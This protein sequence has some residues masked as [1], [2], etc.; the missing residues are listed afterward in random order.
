M[1]CISP[2]S[3]PG[4]GVP[5][6]KKGQRTTISNTRTRCVPYQRRRL[7]SPPSPTSPLDQLDCSRF[8]F[9]RASSRSSA[10]SSVSSNPDDMLTP[11]FMRSLQFVPPGTPVSGP[12]SLPDSHSPALSADLSPV[13]HPHGSSKSPV[14]SRLTPSEPIQRVTVN[15]SQQPAAF[16]H[17][18][19]RFPNCDKRFADKRTTERHRLTHL[20]FG[21]YI[22]PNPACDSRTKAR[23][24]FASDFSLGRHLRLA[25]DDSP[26]AIG[27]G[28]RLSSFRLNAA[29]V[30][31]LVQQAL[32]P[33]DPTIHAPF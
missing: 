10:S 26:C 21:T 3:S 12:S 30:E 7:D 1:S 4:H 22:C 28:Q 23:P 19:C 29:Q 6:G 18:Y 27:K 32:V 25:A 15:A 14:K 33:F 20:D 8:Q 11:E 9:G 24:N 2:S 13:L 31:A 17:R 5:G 16:A